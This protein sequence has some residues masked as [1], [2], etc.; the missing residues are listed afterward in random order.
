VANL[1]INIIP[2]DSVGEVVALAVEAERLGYDRAWVYDE[3]LVTRD[4][5]VTLTA[6]AAAT[7]RLQIGPGITNPYTRHPAQTAAAIASL[8][9]YS[10]GRAFY[11]IGAGGS[12]TLNPLSLSR[13]RP[14]KAVEESIDIARQLFSHHRQSFAGPMFPLHQA[15]IDYGRSN[16]EVW[17]AGRG[18]KMLH[19]GATRA[20]GVMLDFIHKPS[21]GLLID[22][23][24]SANPDARIAYST[25]VATTDHDLDVVRPH[26]T[27][28]LVDAPQ[29]V[30]D[31]LEIS[32]D[33]VQRIRDALAHGLEAA[34]EHVPDE[35]IT[36]FIVSGTPE[37]CAVEIE[38]LMTRHG[39]EEFVLPLFPMADQPQY[40]AQVAQALGRSTAT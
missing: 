35:W 32:P 30:K 26:M 25:S 37:Q 27:Y 16:I 4:L 31:A 9:E 15:S 1:S 39:I 40:L 24:R 36:P 33:A 8:D 14:L 28:R 23:V 7:T 11:G 6:M 10:D 29:G 34:A 21:L 5:Y 17:L 20:D 38:S 3:G 13:D 19:L 2:E 18:P 12:L 22:R